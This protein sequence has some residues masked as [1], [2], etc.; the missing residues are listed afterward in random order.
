MID[1]GL[2]KRFVDPS[3]GFDWATGHGYVGSRKPNLSILRPLRCSGCNQRIPR[4]YYPIQLCTNCGEFPNRYVY[5]YHLLKGW[6][7]G[8]LYARIRDRKVWEELE[9]SW[10]NG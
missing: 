10:A 9:R 8:R 4:V 1:C 5:H 3:E 6:L 2:F 7:L